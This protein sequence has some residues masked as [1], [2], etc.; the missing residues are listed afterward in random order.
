MKQLIIFGPPGVGKGTQADLISN[1]WDLFHFST[2]EFLRKAV[3]E[4]TEFGLKAKAIMDRGELVS[5]EI[6]IGIV[7]EALKFNI[8]PGGFI[9][10]GFP[11]TIQQAIELDEIFV[12][13]NF[14]EV[15]VLVLEADENEI[16][17]RLLNRGRTDDTDEAIRNRL[18]IYLETTAPIIDYYAKKGML[19]EIDGMGEISE[20]NERIQKVL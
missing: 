13:L 16:I 15:K 12:E 18:K 2:G 19:I 8:A 14:R 17:R 10:D 5:D 20:I 6:M 7:K 3:S 1:N 11:R 9:L 4:G